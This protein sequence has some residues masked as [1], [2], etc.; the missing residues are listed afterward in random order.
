MTIKVSGLITNVITD[1]RAWTAAEV[2]AH[3][4][5]GIVMTL[6]ELIAALEAATEPS[7][8]IDNEV[9]ILAYEMG[10]RAERIMIPDTTPLYTASLDAALSLMPDGAEWF[11]ER[12]ANGSMSMVVDGPSRW[13]EAGQ[14]ATPALALCIAALKART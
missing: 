4:E 5:K 9:D 1:T 3:Y 13:A 2:R 7:R 8:E 12:G 11:R 10:W 14:G 6:P